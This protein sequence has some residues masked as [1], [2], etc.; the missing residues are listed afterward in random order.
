VFVAALVLRA[1]FGLTRGPDVVWPD[2]QEYD[3]ISRRLLAEG[4][5]REDL[6]R[7][8]SR[9]PGYPFFLAGCRAVGL[10]D[11]RA[12]YLLQAA[13]GA[14]VCVLVALLGRRLFD[15]RA[16][17]LAGWI[18]AL[19]PYAI[20]FTGT[21]LS[22]TLFTLGL[23]AYVLLLLLMIET[24]PPRRSLLLATAAGVLAG[25][26]TLLRSS[27]MLF[28]FFVVP[29]L[30]L[31]IWK[32][33][34]PTGETRPAAQPAPGGSTEGVAPSAVP[35]TPVVGV[36]MLRCAMLWCVMA[37]VMALTLTPW[38]VRNYRIFN[39]IVPAT[40]QVG[41]S[42]YEAFSP[43]ADGGPAMDRIDWPAVR[44]GPMG[45]LENNDFFKKAAIEYIREHPAR[46]AALAVEKARRF[47]NVVPNHGP[48]RSALY[49]AVS[50]VAVV[51]VYLLA[52]AGVLG[53]RGRAFGLLL[54]PV[55]YFALMHMVFVGSVRYRVPV[56]PF[57]GVLAAAG[58]VW[59][60]SRRR[61]QREERKSDGPLA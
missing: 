23:V 61:A 31:M 40:L 55:L 22:E 5:Y 11:P 20:Y 44:G 29:F 47:W 7:Q 58:A 10:G 53:W 38:T 12:V 6:G 16:G 39:R 9:A 41:E 43:Y 56:T 28:P 34:Q 2:A 17:L 32:R 60:W 13:A 30:A 19:D 27:F 50:V 37:L 33:A 21:L 1:G 42:L 54:S 3:A 59:L 25:G 24:P 52:L 51:P 35:P 36:P 45:E 4:V 46:A 49:V 8:A 18:A 57:L 48:H 14:A 26:L 15:A